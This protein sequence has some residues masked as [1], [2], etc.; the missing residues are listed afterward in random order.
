MKMKTKAGNVK[1]TLLSA[2]KLNDAG[3]DVQLNSRPKLKHL[4]TGEEIPRVK[5]G[6]MYIL[7]M[8]IQVNVNEGDF[9]RQGS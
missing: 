9:H 5:K 7:T 8:W 3:Y 4:K 1:Q 6:G 2:S